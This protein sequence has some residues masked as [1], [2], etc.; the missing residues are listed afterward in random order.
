MRL[1]TSEIQFSQWDLRASLIGDQGVCT[2][3]QGK[4]K[5]KQIIEWVGVY[6]LFTSDRYDIDYSADRQPQRRSGF[7]KRSRDKISISDT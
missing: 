5:A 1:G 2:R 3:G 4:R 7:R 6:W